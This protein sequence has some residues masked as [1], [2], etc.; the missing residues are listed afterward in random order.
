MKGIMTFQDRLLGLTNAI[1]RFP[2]TIIFL[3]LATVINSMD[4]HSS[5][6]YSRYI[7][8]LIVGAFLGIVSQVIYERFFNNKVIRISLFGISAILALIYSYV[9]SNADNI[10][11]EIWIKT[12]VGLFAL[13]I[14]FIW[15][16]VIKSKFS[17]NESFM[18]AFKGFF[19]SLFFSGVIYVGIS[20]II[21]AVNQLLFRIGYNS[22]SHA[23]N[24]IF[25]FFGP[26]YFLSLIPLYTIDYSGDD[27]ETQY[28][29][30]KTKNNVAIASSCPKYLEIL[31][32][33]IIVPLTAVFTVILL[34]Y[35]LGNM[36]GKF[37]SD[38]LLEPMIVTYSITV[39]LIYILVSRMENKL[40]EVFRMIFPKVLI[41][42]VL[43]Q[44]I[45]SIIKIGDMGITY[46]RYYV[47]LYGIFATIAGIAFSIF[48]V[49]KNG[50]IAALLIVFS[51][52][53]I[54]PPIDAF[55]VSK[56]S[57]LKIFESVLNNN[58]MLQEN[59][60]VP[61]KDISSED[62]QKI[63]KVLEYLHQIEYTDKVSWLPK[64][65]DYYSDFYKTFGF[66]QYEQTEEVNQYVY[67]NLNMEDP[68]DISGYDFFIPH[69]VYISNYDKK[70]E[71][72]SK[73]EK[74]NKTYTLKLNV[75]SKDSYLS[76]W[77]E[78]QKEINRFSYDKVLQRFENYAGD[79]K[80]LIDMEEAVF[81]EENGVSS[82]KLVIKAFNMD[83]TADNKSFNI[84]SYIL[85]DI[86]Q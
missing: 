9:I 65:Y 22:Y 34:F 33:Y 73:F 40:A 59:K 6:D 78:N 50:I 56:N 25:L 70:E 83:R 49:R 61:N 71:E 32:S 15:I 58:N 18:A 11:T 86:R 4:I 76:L 1:Y 68:I 30:E 52:I 62:K 85:V 60:I 53:S 26:T 46:N 45:S 81:I 5:N 54:V 79:T 84:E 23:A 13:F 82:V 77:D 3:L 67:L 19:I 57:Q 35:I 36:G 51:M 10:N 31:I 63:I 21:M 12:I 24:I 47:I 44:T 48:P 8:S 14:G 28:R 2:L 69:Y 29:V 80:G 7:L 37:W 16:P 74:S 38:N 39:I 64:D 17:L 42:I 72:I 66:N 43:F 55:T 75:T 27:G 41:P 20:L